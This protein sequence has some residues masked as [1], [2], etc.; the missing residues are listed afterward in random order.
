MVSS[1]RAEAF[2]MTIGLREASERSRLTESVGRVALACEQKVAL[3][4]KEGR[5]DRARATK[6]PQ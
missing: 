1:V 5:F 6:S 4:L 3:D 2:A